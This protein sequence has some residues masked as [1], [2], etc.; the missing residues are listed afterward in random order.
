MSSAVVVIG[1]TDLFYS[2]QNS[3]IMSFDTQ[4][5]PFATRMVDKINPG[6]FCKVQAC[7]NT[8]D[9]VLLLNKCSKPPI[10]LR[11]ID[12]ATWTV[13]WSIECGNIARDIEII[14]DCLS[15]VHQD[16]RTGEKLFQQ[17][18]LTTGHPISSVSIGFISLAKV[19][20]LR[21]PVALR[22]EIDTIVI[23]HTDGRQ[24]MLS[25][26]PSRIKH[27]R[28]T[29]CDRVISIH[30]ADH[31]V[32]FYNVIENSFLD[33][34]DAT[35]DVSHHLDF[36]LEKNT[37]VRKSDNYLVPIVSEHPRFISPNVLDTGMSTWIDL[38]TEMLDAVSLESPG[39][40]HLRPCK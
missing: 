23:F 34:D 33:V 13:L 8:D 3:L 27:V 15:I 40:A 36:T 32:R 26:R 2:S 30:L 39:F 1:F 6:E 22:I 9:I 24:N 7:P 20:L 28:K 35:T 25:L 19:R 18:D 16:E 29:Q 14:G 31:K 4:A 5:P 11:M 17:L 38:S 37:C 10:T 21:V 12:T